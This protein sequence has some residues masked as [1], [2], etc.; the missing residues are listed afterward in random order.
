MLLQQRLGGLTTSYKIFLLVIVLTKFIEF[1]KCF[2]KNLWGS[3]VSRKGLTWERK[4]I[5]QAKIAFF[6]E[7]NEECE[8]IR[9]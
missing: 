2:T 8:N 1:V 5:V 4:E 9:H 3:A 6:E 7:D